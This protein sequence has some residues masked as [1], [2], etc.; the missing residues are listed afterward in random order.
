LAC[1]PG[2]TGC[3][4]AKL[5]GLRWSEIDLEARTITLPRDRTKNRQEHIVPLSG[6]AMEILS[7]VGDRDALASLRQ[8]Q[9]RCETRYQLPLRA[10]K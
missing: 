8:W 4:R 7:R 3:R 9:Y 1:R 2:L 6:A 5:G 10:W